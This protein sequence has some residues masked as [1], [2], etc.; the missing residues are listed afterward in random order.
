LSQNDPKYTFFGSEA[1][2]SKVETAQMYTKPIGL[3]TILLALTF[4]LLAGCKLEI[5]TPPVG[6]R[7][8]HEGGYILPGKRVTFDVYDI[9]YDETWTAVPDAGYVFAGWKQ[10]SNGLCGG[11]FEPC[12]L[13]T[14]GFD[15]YEF[16]TAIL[17]S[18]EVF[19]LEPV[20]LSQNNA[21]ADRSV[22]GSSKEFTLQRGESTVR[23]V[24][25]PPKLHWFWT[26]AEIEGCPE[27][28]CSTQPTIYNSYEIVFSTR[29]DTPLGTYN[30]KHTI[31]SHAH[32]FQWR[33][34]IEKKTS[35][36]LKVVACTK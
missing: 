7:L 6:G 24:Q 14:V 19:Y 29:S 25:L 21:C 32:W 31:W 8:I 5:T 13:T 4:V 23:N 12:H 16:L 10:Q 36:K 17:E 34:K 26:Y 9:Y 20:F 27:N 1:G 35:F 11:G 2:E 3:R 18:D 30:I 15:K 28:M 33:D 22:P